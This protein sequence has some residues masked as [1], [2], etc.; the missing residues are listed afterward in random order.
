MHFTQERQQQA[1]LAATR[2]SVDANKLPRLHLERNLTQGRLVL[3][4]VRIRV[5][6]RVLVILGGQEPRGGGGDLF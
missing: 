2:G 6:I 4:R 1:G 5:R 3:V